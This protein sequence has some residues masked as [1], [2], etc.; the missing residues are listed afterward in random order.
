MTTLILSIASYLAIGILLKKTCRFPDSTAKSL[1]LF[2]I[3]VSLPAL[4]LIHLPS[5]VRNSNIISALAPISMPWIQFFLV[6]PLVSRLGRQF[7]WEPRTTGALILSAG[8]SNTSFIGLPVLESIFG[9]EAVKIGILIDQP[10]SFLVLSTVGLAVA[11]VF[12][13]S[14]RKFE[15]NFQNLIRDILTFPPF[16]AMF[17]ALVWGIGMVELE[18]APSTVLTSLSSTLTPLALI[19]IGFQLR[20]S[21]KS[22]AKQARPLAI[23]LFIKLIAAPLFFLLTYKA[24]FTTL[25][26]ELKVTIVESAMASMI[27]VSALCEERGLDAELSAL[28]AGIGIPLSLVTVQIW[29]AL[30]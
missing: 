19:S 26:L 30:F 20:L 22:F 8:I 25:S 11:T 23:G 10:G 29:L 4:I 7:N 9:P 3:W 18:A 16:I 1:N 15:F 14:R 13:S 24:F 17:V 12:N 5:L 21:A 2:V 6:A 27:S 28:M